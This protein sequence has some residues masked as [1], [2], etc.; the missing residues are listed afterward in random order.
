M[1]SSSEL[2]AN[3]RYFLGGSI[4]E[5]PWL[6]AVVVSLIY[7]AITGAT[8]TVTA[9]FDLNSDNLTTVILAGYV[10]IAMSLILSTVL[11]VPLDIGVTSYFLKLVRGKQTNIGDTFNGFRYNFGSNVMLGLM[12]MLKIM[13]WSLLF[14]IPG[15]IKAYS[16]AINYYIKLDHPEYDWKTC[17][18]ESE[19]MMKGNRC[20][21]FCL[22]MSFIGW[23]IVGTLCRGL[24]TL[25]VDA[26]QRTSI[27]LFYEE[28]KEKDREYIKL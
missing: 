17:L 25:W 7:S 8:N 16:F 15:I 14:I 28:L 12:S 9:G 20:R 11:L 5:Q 18:S 13:L 6:L 10:S 1:L 27:A 22:Q 19:R 21:L 23:M 4:F 26:Y 3:A 2:R 24:G